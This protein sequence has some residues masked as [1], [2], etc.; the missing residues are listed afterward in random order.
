MYAYTN[1]NCQNNS[2]NINYKEAILYQ[3]PI[4]KVDE[5]AH[6]SSTLPST[7]RNDAWK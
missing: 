2:N 6:V 7:S 5:V 3:E 1:T 4:T